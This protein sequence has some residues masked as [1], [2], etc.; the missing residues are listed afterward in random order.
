LLQIPEFL[1]GKARE[2][3]QA[4]FHAEIEDLDA[5]LEEL[6]SQRIEPAIDPGELIRESVLTVRRKEM[7]VGEIDSD[8]SDRLGAHV[9]S[10]AQ[11][12]ERRGH[13]SAGEIEDIRIIEARRFRSA[14]GKP[15]YVWA[16]DSEV[17]IG[18]DELRLRALDV[19]QPFGSEGVRRVHAEHVSGGER[20][21]DIVDADRAKPLGI[22]QRADGVTEPAYDDGFPVMDAFEVGE[23]WHRRTQRITSAV[24]AGAGMALPTWV[25]PRRAKWARGPRFPSAHRSRI[26]QNPTIR[27]CRWIRSSILD[28]AWVPVAARARVPELVPVVVPELVPVTARERALAA[29]R[30]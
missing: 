8:Q 28:R 1:G 12:H 23:S 24:R 5:A 25:Q 30:G 19:L 16:A 15:D 14:N 17:V 22:P 11:R 7:A 29:A 13:G 3:A 2:R 9:R 20:A 26:A 21:L 6:A 27:C 4:A 18:E 10:Q